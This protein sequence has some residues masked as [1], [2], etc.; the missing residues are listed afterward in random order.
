VLGAGPSMPGERP[1]PL[2]DFG[3]VP[4]GDHCLQSGGNFAPK[5]SARAGAYVDGG[6]VSAC[7]DAAIEC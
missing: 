7:G 6:R 5:P 3:F 1:L 4:C 2:F